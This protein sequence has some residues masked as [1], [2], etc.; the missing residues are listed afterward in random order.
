M[1]YQVRRDEFDN[2]LFDHATANG[3][4]AF[5]DHRVTSVTFENESAIA[6]GVSGDGR[7]FRCTARYFVDATGRDTLLG[8][9]L[10][11]KRK[12]PAAPER[13]IVRAFSGVARRPGAG[14]RQHQHLPL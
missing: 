9:H 7:A 8:N 14:C 5:Q 4:H 3:V 12:S 13:G 11:I 6:D 1:R 10:G 2:L